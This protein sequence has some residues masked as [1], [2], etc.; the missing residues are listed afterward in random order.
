MK[1]NFLGVIIIAIGIIAFFQVVSAQGE[2]PFYKLRT[3]YLEIQETSYP[4][5]I[6]LTK[7]ENNKEE[8]VGS[9]KII[10]EYLISDLLENEFLDE[11]PDLKPGFQDLSLS[12][13]ANEPIFNKQDFYQPPSFW[14]KSGNSIK[15]FLGMEIQ[16]LPEYRITKQID[17]HTKDFGVGVDK[18][19]S[20]KTEVDLSQISLTTHYKELGIEN[21]ESRIKQTLTFTNNNEQDLN[22]SLLLKHKINA[23]RIHWDNR[24]FSLSENPQKLES[25]G[26]I[27]FYSQNMKYLSFY[28]YSDIPNEFE[29]ELWIER[30][31]GQALLILSLNVFLRAGE[32]KTI[33]PNYNTEITPQAIIE[34]EDG[35]YT[36]KSSSGEVIEI[37]VKRHS[38]LA[39]Y[40]KLHRWDEECFVSVSL[41]TAVSTDTDSNLQLQG[42]KLKWIEEKKEAHFYPLEKTEEHAEGFEFEVILKEKPASNII[43]LDIETKGL[44]FYYQ[45]DMRSEKGVFQPENVVDSYAV[46]HESKAGNYEAFPNGKNYRAGKAFHIYRPKIIDSAGT[47]VWGEL[48][49]DEQTKTLTITI[50]QNWLD[51]AIYPVSVD[52]TFGYE[53]KGGTLDD[54]QGA[55]YMYGS[56]F[57]SPSDVGTIQNIKF[58]YSVPSSGI[59]IKGIIALA[60]NLNIVTNGISDSVYDPSFAWDISTAVYLQNFSV[61]GQDTYPQAVFFK[62]DGT[63]MYVVGRIGVDVNEYDLSTPW[64]VATAVYLQ[65]FS[66]SNE[67]GVPRG[68]FFKPDGTKMYV[69]GDSGDNVNE[70]DLSTPWNVATAVYLQCFSV[71]EEEQS[72]HAVFFKPDGTKMYVIGNFGVDVNEYDLSTPWNVSTAVYL[73]CFSVAEEEAGPRGIFFSSDG[74]KMYVVGVWGDE[75]NEYDISMSTDSLETASYSTEPTL[76]ASTDYVLM[77]VQDVATGMYYDTGDANQAYV[78]STNSY[79]SPS[80]PTDATNVNNYKY[81][82]YCTYATAPSFTAGPSDGGSSGTSPTDVDSNVSFTATGTDGDSDNYYLAICKGNNITANNEAAPTCDDGNWCISSSTSSGSEAGCNYTALVGDSESNVWHAFVCDHNTSS[83]CSSSSQGAANGGTESPFKVNHRPNFAALDISKE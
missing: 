16:S 27:S 70:Y 7:K 5:N 77:I 67:E 73:Q 28:D 36:L 64:N 43:S 68:V 18:S 47:E 69:I 19:H 80:H 57:T 82:I 20:I 76:T 58:H 33:D 12:I 21:N 61:A 56:K 2:N 74:T 39:P 71:A 83:L 50:D 79:D 46:Y 30:K 63:K 78:D 41:P 55:D 65:N 53:T 8:I 38:P 62:P 3:S 34:M 32:T 11:Y 9:A 54:A 48:N 25:P 59:N 51:N 17:P 15:S 75:V 72:P 45:P 10:D 44:K 81:S 4:Q 14:E 49:I 24:I 22:L 13:E 52:P 35:T 1:K 37:G 6:P 60:S 66:V 29:P 23:E 31:N 42:N 40:V 26:K